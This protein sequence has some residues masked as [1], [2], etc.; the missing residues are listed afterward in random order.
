MRKTKNSNFVGCVTELRWWC[1]RQCGWVVA[2][3]RKHDANLHEVYIEVGAQFLYIG[4]FSHSRWRGDFCRLG[5]LEWSGKTVDQMRGLMRRP[6]WRKSSAFPLFSRT[7]RADLKFWRVVMTVFFRELCN[8]T[9]VFSRRHSR[10]YYSE[11]IWGLSLLKGEVSLIENVRQMNELVGDL[12]CLNV[13]FIAVS[14][15]Q[16]NKIV[17]IRHLTCLKRRGAPNLWRLTVLSWTLRQNHF[18]AFQ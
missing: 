4:S 9:L 16:P 17:G 8:F 1:V 18:V 3:L 14:A 12:L 5:Q 7:A 13:T 2:T 6:I 11:N 10:R 15:I